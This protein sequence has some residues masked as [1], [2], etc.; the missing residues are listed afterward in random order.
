MN[1][2]LDGIGCGNSTIKKV[3]FDNV[4]VDMDGLL[5]P[6]APLKAAVKMGVNTT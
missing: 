4:G 6:M 2:A 1:R 3:L 5:G